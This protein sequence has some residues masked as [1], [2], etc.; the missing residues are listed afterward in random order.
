MLGEWTIQ[1]CL[2]VGF[3]GILIEMQSIPMIKVQQSLLD[4]SRVLDG[5]FLYGCIQKLTLP[6]SRSHRRLINPW[7]TVSERREKRERESGECFLDQNISSE[8]PHQ[9]TAATFS[10]SSGSWKVLS[11]AARLR[12]RTNAVELAEDETT[13]WSLT[14]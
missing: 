8:N 12:K 14:G 13:A 10:M 5:V 11:D 7:E 3:D 1:E 9:L 6:L 2:S 4:R